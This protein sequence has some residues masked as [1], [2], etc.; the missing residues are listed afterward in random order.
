VP[1]HDGWLR[2]HLWYAQN[3]RHARELR[4][5][6]RHGVVSSNRRMAVEWLVRHSRNTRQCAGND[7]H[8]AGQA[9]QESAFQRSI[10]PSFMNLYTPYKDCQ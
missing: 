1:K 10:S 8:A 9:I 6:N 5:Y 2:Y 3:R 7:C 4:T